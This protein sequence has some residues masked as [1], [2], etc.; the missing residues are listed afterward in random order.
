MKICFFT[1]YMP[2]PLIGGVERV[3]Y[4]LSNGFRKVGIEVYHC[5]TS[6]TGADLIIPFDI[7]DDEKAKYV[8]AFLIDNGIEI[9][10]DQFGVSYLTHPGISR[11]IK[12]IRC[13][14]TP[15]FCKHLVRNLLETFSFYSLRYSLLN[16]A[17]VINTPLRKYR[18]KYI[19]KALKDKSQVDKLV[20]LCRE[21]ANMVEDKYGIPGT[22]LEVIPNAI[23]DSLV[24]ATDYLPKTKT[25]MWCGRIVNNHKNILFLPRLWKALMS[26]HPDWDFVIVGD[27]IDRALLERK[28]KKFGLSRIQITG[29]I[30]PSHKYQESKI[31]VFPSFSEGWGLVL[32]EAMANNCVPVVFDSAPVFHDIICNNYNGIIVPDMD[33]EAFID[34]CDCLMNNEDMRADM[35]KNAQ[36]TVKNFSIEKVLEIWLDLF[37][38]LVD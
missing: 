26:K 23:D 6:G 9:L 1:H 37:N 31:F 32:L 34:A 7:D 11:D 22:M 36:E 5:C 24:C 38:R 17:F 30:N 4:N 10:I 16:I 20:Y 14:H 8:N 29:N 3:T 13:L 18:K 33:E 21:Y 12:I 19:Y 28:I 2:N 35:A 15:P 27:G 25:I